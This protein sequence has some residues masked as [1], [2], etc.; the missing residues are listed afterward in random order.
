MSV[1]KPSQHAFVEGMLTAFPLLLGFVPVVLNLQ[2]SNYG[3]RRLL[4]CLLYL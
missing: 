4:Y 2:L 3:L 1:S